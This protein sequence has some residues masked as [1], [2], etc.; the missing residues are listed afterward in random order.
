MTSLAF[1]LIRRSIASGRVET[2]RNG[3][4]PELA[5][6]LFDRSEWHEELRG[7]DWVVN[8]WYGSHAATGNPWHVRLVD[9]Y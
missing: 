9:I 8:N 5:S 3:W 4:T 1:E 2:L 6:T 7:D